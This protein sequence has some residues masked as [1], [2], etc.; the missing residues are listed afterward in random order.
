M[1]ASVVLAGNPATVAT[2][3]ASFPSSS[4]LAA[5]LWVHRSAVYSM[6]R[7]PARLPE[8]VAECAQLMD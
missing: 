1:L 7:S 6:R 8:S 5:I 3:R 2:Q 4:A